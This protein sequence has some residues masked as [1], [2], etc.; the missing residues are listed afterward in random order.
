MQLT[1]TSTICFVLLPKSHLKRLFYKAEPS[2]QA[3][4]FLLTSQGQNMEITQVPRC[5]LGAPSSDQGENSMGIWEKALPE[6]SQTSAL[7]EQAV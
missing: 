5:V 1:A 2:R 6:G 3:E 4:P 7:P